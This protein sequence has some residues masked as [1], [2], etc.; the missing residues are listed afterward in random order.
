MT[1]RRARARRAR[2]AKRALGVLVAL[3]VL[4]VAS[5][6]SAHKPSDSYVTLE[7]SGTVVESRWDIALRDLDYTLGLDRDGDG[8]ITWGEVRAREADIDAYAIPR[9]GVTADGEPCRPSVREHQIVTHSDGAYVVLRGLFTCTHEPRTIDLDYA[10]F[11]ENDPQHRGLVHLD[12]AGVT[13]ALTFASDHRHEHIEVHAVHRLAQFA[14][15]VGVGI[16]HIWSGYDH[17][18]FLI[19]LLLPSV[20]S[21][22]EGES[23]MRDPAHG[24]WQPLPR[25]RPAL[26]DVLRIVTAFTVAH[27]LTLSLAALDVVRLPSRLTE[28]AIAASV[29]VAAANN[30]LPILREDRWLAAFSLG[31]LHGFGFSATLVDLGLPRSSL[32]LTLFGFNLGVEIGQL[33]IVAAFLPL[34]FAARKTLA[35]R[36]YVVVGGS[37][38][39]AILASVWLVER[40]FAIKILT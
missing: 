5:V 6:A 1:R 39:I 10:L 24:A 12:A 15:I 7:A 26:F 33:T 8:T 11:F 16:H 37:V 32:L 38:A 30:V 36:R 17:L 21:R 35:Y 18:L 22:R 9:L 23:G 28:S 25:F 19:A 4:C 3:F 29:V 14:S 34:A 13:S 31:L 20:L 27:S 2:P 40:A